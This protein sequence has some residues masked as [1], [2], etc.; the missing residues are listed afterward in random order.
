MAL[1]R[2]G[3]SFRLVT[4]ALN[5]L[6]QPILMTAR[7]LR[8]YAVKIMLVAFLGTHIPLLLRHHPALER[9]HFMSI[10]AGA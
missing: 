7:G 2:S 10:Q 4:V 1:R 6:L 9:G 5:E 3:S 8:R